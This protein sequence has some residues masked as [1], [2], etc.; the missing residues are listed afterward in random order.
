M[1]A[2]KPG[3]L[4]F[5]T[6][7]ELSAA[8]DDW[9]PAL[10]LGE[11]GFGEVFEGRLRG[12]PVAI[13]RSTLPEAQRAQALAEFMAEANAMSKCRHANLLPLLGACIGHGA[14]LCLVFPYM[15]G[16]SLYG[17]LF[18]KLRA[19]AGPQYDHACTSS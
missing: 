5:I 19:A 16:G 17:R 18:P 9:A 8:T 6:Y 4:Q 10:R 12:T 13:K 3:E 2:L 1:A 14:P 7:G 11:G 15:A